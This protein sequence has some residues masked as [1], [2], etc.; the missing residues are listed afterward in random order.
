MNLL[1]G[2]VL[3]LLC[4]TI[5]FD[6]KI[7]TYIRSLGII[8]ISIVLLFIVFYLFTQSPILGVIGL[9]ASYQMM[10]NGSV[11]YIQPPLPPDD[12][13]TPSQFQDTLEENVVKN[14]VPLIQTQSPVHLNFKYKADDTHDA[15]PI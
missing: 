5:L 2:I 15:S 4:M 10:Q 3:V 1:H 6:I 13:A 9:I 11:R 8:P 14:M 12:F 7:P